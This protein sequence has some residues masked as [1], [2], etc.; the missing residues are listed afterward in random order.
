MN[1]PRIA[2]DGFIVAALE[3]IPAGD[4]QARTRLSGVNDAM[5]TRPEQVLPNTLPRAA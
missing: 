5:E 3:S 2:R 4:S 1:P